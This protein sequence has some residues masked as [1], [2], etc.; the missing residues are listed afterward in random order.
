MTIGTLFTLSLVITLLI[1]NVIFW[2]KAGNPFTYRDTRTHMR[3]M[4]NLSWILSLLNI[5]LIGMVI[6]RLAQ[7]LNTNWDKTII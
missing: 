3:G 1:I 5:A 2:R 4:M 6:L 7:F